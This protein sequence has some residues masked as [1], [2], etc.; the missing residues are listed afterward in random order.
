MRLARG[1]HIA[2]F[3]WPDRKNKDP[4]TSSALL[5]LGLRSISTASSHV[6]PLFCTRCLTLDNTAFVSMPSIRCLAGAIVTSIT[7]L[8][9]LKSPLPKCPEGGN[10]K[11]CK[12][13]QLSCHNTTVVQDLC[14]FNAPG[15]SL[16]LTQ[17]WD[18]DPATGPDDAWTIHG[19]WVIRLLQHKQ[20]FAANTPL[21]PT[22]A[23]AP[24]S[25]TATRAASTATSPRSSSPSKRT[26][27]WHT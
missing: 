2:T 22:T 1:V 24:T 18:F 13:T 25:S 10:V 8:L 17:F 19:L 4:S 6:K 15:G 16:L 5:T 26:I 7:G 11:T 20:Y 21:S 3:P 23:T 12:N 14:C 9:G 27:S